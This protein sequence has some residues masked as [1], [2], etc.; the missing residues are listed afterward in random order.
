MDWESGAR[1]RWPRWLAKLAFLAGVLAL[2]A[3]AAAA[4]GH[5][6]TSATKAQEPLHGPH[7]KLNPPDP[8][9]A[10]GFDHFYNLQYDEAVEDFEKAL[11][12]FPNDPFAVNHLLEAVLFRE[13]HREG[14][15]DAQLYLS[16]E[17]VHIKKVPPDEKAIARVRR[18]SKR[19]R[20][21]EQAL[22]K[23]NPKDAK[24]LY[25]QSVTRGLHAAEQ[26]LVGKEWFSALRN[27]LGAYDDA[28]HVLQIDPH[29]NDAKLIVGI[30]NY[31]V[32]S[33]PWAVKL[34]ALVV[35]IHGSKTKGLRLIRQAAKADGEA[36]VDA[37]T[38]LALFLAREQ[39]YPQALEQVRWLYRNFPHNF[40][41]GLSE[42]GLLH[43]CGKVQEAI[44]A[45]HQLIR[46]SR[47]GQFPREKVGMAAL[48]L[49]N[50]LRKEKNWQ[51]AAKAYDEVK[52]LPNSTPDLI[53]LARL[54]AGEM[55][56]K[57]GER[58]LAKQR[59]QQVLRETKNEK[60]ANQAKQWL[61]EPYT[62]N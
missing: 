8:A 12:K 37:R 38:T 36:S 6:K 51:A 33:L 30:Y 21:L 7:L 28:N 31:V 55:Y 59:Y 1:R 29:Y 14:K 52:S 17:F 45:Y 43:S 62:G 27:G 53:A 58:K 20:S 18:L 24:A 23:K 47:K 42:A 35:A 15:L 13:L 40:I 5:Q 48:N 25:A 60:L 41:Y 50:V 4:Q 61:K 56:D 49:G 26:A 34:A 39:K 11:A 54:K 57:V 22:L 2:T 44:H 19:A 16:N 9:T 10:E 46:L 3:S 32:G